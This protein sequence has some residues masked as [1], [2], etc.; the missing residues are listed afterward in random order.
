[1]IVETIGIIAAVVPWLSIEL[2]VI[3]NDINQATVSNVVSIDVST[4]GNTV[5]PGKTIQT[6]NTSASVTIETTVNGKI[7]DSFATTSNGQSIENHSRTE[8]SGGVVERS[9]MI[10]GTSSLSTSTLTSRPSKKVLEHLP[11]ITVTSSSTLGSTTA[12]EVSADRTVHQ[13]NRLFAG[14]VHVIRSF[15]QKIFWWE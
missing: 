14:V 7:V 10:Q 1:M 3:G 6:G 11:L 15:I 9:V 13:T 12:A 8:V 5:S 4:G 2:P